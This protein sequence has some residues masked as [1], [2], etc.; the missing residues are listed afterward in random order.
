MFM[1]T[2]VPETIDEIDE[3][4]EVIEEWLISGL[5]FVVHLFLE[6]EI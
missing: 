1:E 2:D 3:F 6:A 4:T 5:N